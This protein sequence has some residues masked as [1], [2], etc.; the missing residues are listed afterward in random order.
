MAAVGNLATAHRVSDP[1]VRLGPSCVPRPRVCPSRGCFR[2]PRAP[3]GPLP[4]TPVQASEG[5]L[6]PSPGSSATKR[7][8]RASA[9]AVRDPSPPFSRSPRRSIR[10]H[11]PFAPIRGASGARDPADPSARLGPRPPLVHGFEATWKAP[12]LFASR[13]STPLTC[14]PAAPTDRTRA[15]RAPSTRAIHASAR[16]T[17]PRNRGPRPRRA[18]KD[19]APDAGP[20]RW[21][22]RTSGRRG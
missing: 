1:R 6:G 5:R 3:S 14:G 20:E 11:R 16:A 8:N 15:R 4:G 18:P 10:R 12:H 22:R 13:G 19:Q 7:V 21:A 17:A 2:S 9:V